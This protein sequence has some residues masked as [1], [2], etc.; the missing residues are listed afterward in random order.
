MK[1]LK[2]LSIK[3]LPAKLQ[4]FIFEKTK[5]EKIKKKKKI[6]SLII[7]YLTRFGKKILWNSKMKKLYFIALLLL[8]YTVYRYLSAF[9]EIICSNKNLN[10]LKILKH[11]RPRLKSYNPTFFCFHPMIQLI[12]GVFELKENYI[13]KFSKEVSAY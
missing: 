9:Y 2:T 6:I 4:S 13:I 8:A 3:S 12:M 11:I 10:N 5:I 1:I 7:R